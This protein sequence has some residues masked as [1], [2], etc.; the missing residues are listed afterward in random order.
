MIAADTRKHEASVNELRMKINLMQSEIEGLTPAV[1]TAQRGE[2]DCICSDVQ[3]LDTVNTPADVGKGELSDEDPEELRSLVESLRRKLKDS[4]SNEMTTASELTR[5][6]AVLIASNKKREA[7]SAEMAVRM[8]AVEDISVAAV[9][10]EVEAEAAAVSRTSSGLTILMGTESTEP[11]NQ[12]CH[13]KNKNANIASLHA[14]IGAL[15]DDLTEAHRSQ[16][17]LVAVVSSRDA[18][19]AELKEDHSKVA[20][21]LTEILSQNEK[22]TSV[23]AELRRTI[24]EREKKSDGRT[25]NSTGAAGAESELIADLQIQLAIKRVSENSLLLRE[26]QELQEEVN[27]LQQEKSL[28]NDLAASL[29]I[30]GEKYAELAAAKIKLESSLEASNRTVVSLA[31]DIEVLRA[32]VTDLYRNV[33]PDE[34]VEFTNLRRRMTDAKIN[35]KNETDNEDQE[36]RFQSNLE[37]WYGDLRVTSRPTSVDLGPDDSIAELDIEKLILESEE[38][39]VRVKEKRVGFKQYKLHRRECTDKVVEKSASAGRK[40]EIAALLAQNCELEDKLFKSE[41]AR[42]L[43]TSE[44]T[45]SKRAGGAEKET[46]RLAGYSS[47]DSPLPTSLLERDALYIRGDFVASPADPDPDPDPA[48]STCSSV[49]HNHD[50]YHDQYHDHDQYEDHDGDQESLLVERIFSLENSAEVEKRKFEGRIQILLRA[51]GMYDSTYSN[52]IAGTD[53]SDERWKEVVRAQSDIE[54]KKVMTLK[55]CLMRFS[56]K[57]TADEV[58]ELEDYGVVLAPRLNSRTRNK[59]L[60][61][62]SALCFI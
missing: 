29:K 39:L 57:L 40:R 37:S 17:V 60:N 16:E 61:L 19:L 30:A 58:D 25:P 31:G 20:A 34:S 11:I 35:F 14:E 32:L 56:S 59:G 2:S 26:M 51:S 54:R 38:E 36:R 52:F 23:C 6:Q 24:S 43:L 3:S 47:H 10:V 50:Q 1:N 49:D 4:M 8:A 41:S 18:E 28:N 46:D 15:T 45:A 5:M 9:E 53:Q 21:E 48:D 13:Y 42:L 55:T 62:G 44:A 27:D 22:L 7:E 33:S 12:N